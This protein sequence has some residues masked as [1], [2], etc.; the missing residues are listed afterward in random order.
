MDR[1]Q[2][3]VW[4]WA[5]YDWANSAFATVV[6]AGFFPLLF[7]DYWNA[8]VTVERANLR[9]GWS[10]AAASLILVL[11][12][13]LLGALADNAG[14]HKRLLFLFAAP[15]MAATA[16]LT[17][18]PEGAWLTASLL[19]V[20]AT[21]GFMGANLLYDALLVS[22]APPARWHSVSGLGFGLG[23]LG[24]G[25]LYLLCVATALRPQLFGLADST[26]AAL[27]AFTLTAIWWAIFSL[28]LLLLVPE[29]GRLQK[30]GDASLW[31]QSIGQVWR[32]LRRLRH[33]RTIAI[34]LLAYWL[35]IDGVGTV[36]RMAVAYGRA[37]GFERSHLILALLLVQ[38][39][40]FPAAIA[41]GHLGERI[42]PR[43][44]I[45][46]GLAVYILVCT[47]GA[48]IRS[49]WEFFVI[50]V[51]VGLVQ[52]GIQALSRSA[53]ARLLPAH[54][55]GEFFG[56][57]NLMGKFAALIG[58]PLFG[59]FGAWFGDVRYSMLAL[60]LLFVAGGLVLSRLPASAFTAG[61]TRRP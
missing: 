46:I 2:R 48:L 43:R 4:S 39:V 60:V 50:A 27:G 17:L 29:P 45:Y 56:F 24:G 14:A 33:H 58:P 6:L 32:T 11:S 47:W 35:Y 34:F 19:F 25:L 57:Y 53:Y 54:R 15:G 30:S 49:P 51:L 61:I 52:G 42:G 21:L 12:A 59:L 5:F 31:R 36:I 22:V 1:S 38:F 28:P 13:P 44:G 8:G 7:Q 10:N 20:C 26:E 18:V 55:S 37:L 16:A 3:A 40:G 41:F 9:L 23:Y